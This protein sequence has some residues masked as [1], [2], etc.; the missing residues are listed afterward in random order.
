MLWHAGGVNR[1]ARDRRGINHVFTIALMRQQLDLP[2]VLGDGFTDDP[3]MRQLLGFGHPFARS[4][5]EFL[6][7]AARKR[8]AQSAPR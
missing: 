8:K 5:E 7:E 1:T 4:L 3:R 2:S 6:A